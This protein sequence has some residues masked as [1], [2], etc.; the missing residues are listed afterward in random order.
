MLIFRNQ[1]FYIRVCSYLLILIL[2]VSS[3]FEQVFVHF[4]V[5]YAIQ[6]RSLSFRS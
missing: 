3:I 6:W 5:N 2:K 4:K 1:S